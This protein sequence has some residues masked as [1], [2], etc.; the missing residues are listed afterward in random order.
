MTVKQRLKNFMAFK[1][2][3]DYLENKIIN[4]R[5]RQTSIRSSSNVDDVPIGGCSSDKLS[6]NVAAYLDLVNEYQEKLNKLYGEQKELETMQ[7]F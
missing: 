7:Q 6:E 4:M 2:E 5:D 3:I 1:R